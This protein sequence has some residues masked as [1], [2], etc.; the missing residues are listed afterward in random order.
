MRMINICVAIVVFVMSGGVSAQQTGS[1]D[2]TIKLNQIPVKMDNSYGA[3]IARVGEGR[4]HQQDATVVEIPPGGKVAPHR[5]LFEEVIYIISGQGQTLMW[6]QEGGKKERYEWKAGDLLS[7]SLNAFH[8]HINTSD[9]PARYISITSAP[10]MLNI[11]HDPVFLAGVKDYSFEDRWQKGITQKAEYFPDGTPG[12]EELRMSVGHLLPN[13]V[14]RELK[15]LR[16]GTRGIRLLPEGDGD[17]AGNRLFEM[18]V[19]E[20]K[21][22]EYA[23]EEGERMHKHPWEVAYI[24]LEGA[25]YSLLKKDK[26]GAPQRR[27]NWQKG[28]LFIV[29]SNEWHEN[30]PQDNATT[31]YL[32]VKVGGYF[33]NI[34]NIKIVPYSNAPGGPYSAN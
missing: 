30:H 5:H 11:F 3:S 2:E 15:Q 33:K 9:K 22:E 29:E 21:A 6:N 31:R 10:V 25:G 1:A 27:V 19:H 14:G 28:D 34:G 7:P 16:A 20:K 24:V 13:I 26:D 32:Q 12:S 4:L 23:D 18:Q 8:E 17:M